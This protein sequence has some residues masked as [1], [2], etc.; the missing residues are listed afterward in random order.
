MLEENQAAAKGWVAQGCLFHGAAVAAYPVLI[1]AEFVTF[2]PAPTTQQIRQLTY[3]RQT[4]RITC[5]T[6]ARTQSL[7]IIEISEYP[8]ISP[9]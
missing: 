1:L 5:K 7:P 4:N 3:K 2:C 8:C 9:S 6:H